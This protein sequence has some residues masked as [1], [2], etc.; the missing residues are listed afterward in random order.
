MGEMS[1]REK[2]ALP[3]SLL[4]DPLTNRAA[5]YGNT[6]RLITPLASEELMKF[7]KSNASKTAAWD[8][9]AHDKT[10]MWRPLPD[11]ATD[12]VRARCVL[13]WIRR[14]NAPDAYW[15]TIPSK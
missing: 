2:D 7:A 6:H 13:V 14:G 10:G 11:W 8:E 4:L 12:E 1:S 5:A 15:R 9:S 3:Y